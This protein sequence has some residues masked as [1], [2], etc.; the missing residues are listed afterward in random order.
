MIRRVAVWRRLYSGRVDE[1]GNLVRYTLENAARK[2]GMSKKSLDDYLHQIRMGKRYK[3]EFKKN[4][5]DLF[6]TLRAFNRR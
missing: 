2:M 3:F 4:Q 5:D 1:K 6:G